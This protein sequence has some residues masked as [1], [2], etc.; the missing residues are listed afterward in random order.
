M[1]LTIQ[2]EKELTHWIT[3]LTQHGY[4]SR[5]RTVCELAEIIPNPHIFSVNDKMFNLSIMIHLVKIGSPDLCHVI[6]NL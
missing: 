2:E 3:T 6:D 4:A 5:Y 1:H